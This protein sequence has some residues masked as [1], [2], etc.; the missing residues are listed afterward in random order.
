MTLDSS[1]LR[2]IPGERGLGREVIGSRIILKD[3]TSNS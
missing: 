3:M 2:S 1:S